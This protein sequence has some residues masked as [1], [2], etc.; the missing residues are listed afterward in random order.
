ML[1]ILHLHFTFYWLGLELEANHQ[2]KC[3]THVLMFR[4]GVVWELDVDVP[5]TKT[6]LYSFWASQG[7]EENNKNSEIHEA[8]L[9]GQE[10]TARKLSHTWDQCKIRLFWI[11][12]VRNSS[13]AVHFFL[14]SRSSSTLVVDEGC[15]APLVIFCFLFL[16]KGSK[17]VTETRNTLSIFP[18]FKVFYK[19]E[20]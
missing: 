1:I 12:F 3:N 14:I 20:V 2:V 13:W 17:D 19:V 9:R 5:N 6:Y 4:E 16:I 8:G 18:R 7:V 11:T 15:F 10:N